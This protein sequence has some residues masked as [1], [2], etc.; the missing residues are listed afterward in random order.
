MELDDNLMEDLGNHATAMI[1]D[2]GDKILKKW[3]R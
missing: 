3:E 2:P 1:L